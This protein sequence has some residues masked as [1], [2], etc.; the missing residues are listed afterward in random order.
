MNDVTISRVVD[1]AAQTLVFSI[2]R[3]IQDLNLGT[4]LGLQHSSDYGSFLG[5]SYLEIPPSSTGTAIRDQN[6]NHLS[7]LDTGSQRAP[8]T[9]IPPGTHANGSPVANV[10]QMY[11]QRIDPNVMPAPNTDSG[12]MD[13]FEPFH[14]GALMQRA[15]PGQYMHPFDSTSSFNN[16]YQLNRDTTYPTPADAFYHNDLHSYGTQNQNNT[17]HV[18][19][20]NRTT[21]QPSNAAQYRNPGEFCHP[22][23]D[24]RR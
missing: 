18:L 15:I 16:G 6:I 14:P 10:D 23:H 7:N 19:Y 13:Q 17:R 4:S 8:Q 2:S 1:V 3:G 12:A 9:D 20:Q 21:I 22:P 24:Q 5:G 11:T